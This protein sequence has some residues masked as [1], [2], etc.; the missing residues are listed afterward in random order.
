M[1]WVVGYLPEI[2]SGVGAAVGV[3]GSVQASKATEAGYKFN[4]DV[5]A[6]NA[7]LAQQQAQR[8]EEAA[9]RE[10]RQVLARQR[11]AIAESGLG[12]GG[13]AGLLAEQNAVTQELDALNIRYGGT[14]RSTGLLAQSAY[15]RSAG[16]AARSSG[17]MLAG[18]QLLAGASDTY[19]GYRLRQRN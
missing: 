1:A 10:G 16:A 11:G 8:D 14:L 17:R 3:A 9:R 5:D 4:A 15:G 6:K 18:A 12:A 7:V 13:S 19:K 2:I